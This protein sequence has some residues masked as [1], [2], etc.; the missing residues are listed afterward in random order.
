MF[1]EMGERGTKGATPL[2]WL[3]G[4]T[5]LGKEEDMAERCRSVKLSM[6]RI[7]RTVV[8]AYICGKQILKTQ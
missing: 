2:K 1:T 8:M 5:S 7:I 4:R 6:R 3:V